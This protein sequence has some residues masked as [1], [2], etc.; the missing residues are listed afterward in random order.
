MMHL[1]TSDIENQNEKLKQRCAMYSK[2]PI[3]RPPMGLSK[4]G[5]KDRLL[6]SLKGGL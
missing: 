4:S 3:L 1:G 2:I 6:D 5:L